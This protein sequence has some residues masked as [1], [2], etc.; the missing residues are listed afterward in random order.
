M[1]MKM[2]IKGNLLISIMMVAL[3][4]VLTIPAFMFVKKNPISQA[5]GLKKKAKK[6][7]QN[8][9]YASAYIS[10]RMLLDSLGVVSDPASLNYANAAYLSSVLLK[11]GTRQGKGSTD[12]ADSSLLQIGSFG[13]EKYALLTSSTDEK[14]SSLAFNQLGYSQLKDGELFGSQGS[15]SVLLMALEHF[16][17]ALRKDPENDSARF[18]YELV[19]KVVDYP[20]T[21]LSEVKSL[22][23][24]KRYREAAALL[25]KGMR[26]DPRL[27][28]QQD[29]MQRLR[30][31]IRIDS[32]GS[33]G[34]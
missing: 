31:V 5:N 16:K 21:V 20:E 4:I 13:K 11:N 28:Q 29:F 19:K 6:E 12:A 18:N 22:I 14:I 26:R 3:F 24:E 30:T 32:L 23:A 17:N 25:E 7:Y 2:K 34:S 10:Y 33:K 15:D 27:R 1:K 8:A 9:E